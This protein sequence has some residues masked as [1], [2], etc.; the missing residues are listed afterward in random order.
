VCPIGATATTAAPTADA[1]L[2]LTPHATVAVLRR[3]ADIIA[4]VRLRQAQKKPPPCRLRDYG[5][6]YGHHALCEVPVPPRDRAPCRFYSFGISHDYTFDADLA[7]STARCRGTALDPSVV[8]PTKLTYGVQ[9]MQVAA[10]TLDA[11]ADAKWPAVTTVPALMRW[12][13]HS[14]LDVLKM[15]CE[16]C[17]YA[18]AEDIAQTDPDFFTRVDQFAVE[19]HVP[20]PYTPEGGAHLSNYALLLQQLEAAGHALVHVRMSGCR[21]SDEAR[22][23]HPLLTEAGYPCAV[24][25]MCQNLL[26]A[27]QRLW[28]PV[29]A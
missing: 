20:L 28:T 27:H 5:I 13:G 24:R 26:F 17:E 1:S 14:R 9:F 4:T 2:P 3:W 11:A 22:G 10:R 29:A 23:C 7:N 25:I 12:L 21:A 8:Y 6:G 19:V 16:G 15:D 18:L